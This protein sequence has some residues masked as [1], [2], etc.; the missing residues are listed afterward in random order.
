MKFLRVSVRKL[1]LLLA[2]SLVPSIAGLLA[3]SLA[4]TPALAERH[5]GVLAGWNLANL[6]IEG[7]EGLDMRSAFAAGA[8]V[9]F[10]LNE[11][12]GIRVEPT[13][14]SKGAKATE[15][16]A[17]WSTMDGVTFDLDYI[18]IPVLFRFD[19]AETESRAYLLGGL[20]FSIATQMEAK[21]VQGTENETVDFNDVFSPY[22]LSLD[23]GAGIGFPVGAAQRLMFDGRAAIGLIDINEGGTVVFNGAPLTV[24]SNATRTMDFR[25]FATYLFPWGK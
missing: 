25:L 6:S 15:R 11:K 7:A 5:I 23:L 1:V 10:A 17:Y 16:N 24:P 3:L 4:A 19:L 8:V 13:F 12:M 21:L 14:L 9:D 18:D 2:G 20:G 22:D